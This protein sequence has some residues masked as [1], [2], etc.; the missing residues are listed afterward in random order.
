ML[1][2]VLGREELEQQMRATELKPESN[3]HLRGQG[4]GEQAGDLA[5]FED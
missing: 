4:S 5:L 2:Q 3:W 1:F